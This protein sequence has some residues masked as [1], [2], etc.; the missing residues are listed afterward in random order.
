MACI[1]RNEAILYVSHYLS[2][3]ITEEIPAEKYQKIYVR[4]SDL[5]AHSLR[6]LSA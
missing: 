5:S 4:L 3:E 1:Q 2:A 6:V